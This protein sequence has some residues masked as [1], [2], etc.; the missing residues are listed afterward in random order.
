[1]FSS[2]RISAASSTAFSASFVYTI[3]CSA[4]LW[5]LESTRVPTISYHGKIN[6]FS[7][8][9]LFLQSLYFLC[10]VFLSS[11]CFS[12]SFS[13]Q[14]WFHL[15][16]LKGDLLGSSLL[17]VR[18]LPYYVNCSEM[19]IVIWGYINQQNWTELKLL[20]YYVIK[21]QTN[22]LTVAYLAVPLDL[23]VRFSVELLH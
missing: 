9:N 11:H 21:E 15:A 4:V 23:A 5:L 14:Q 12:K 22:W 6:W 3:M 7:W 10:T 2:F 19:I 13:L 17:S 8:F 16:L 18:S 20:H 1:M